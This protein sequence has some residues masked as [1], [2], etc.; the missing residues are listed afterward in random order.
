MADKIGPLGLFSTARGAGATCRCGTPSLSNARHAA[1][2]DPQGIPGPHLLGLWALSRVLV[3]G[4]VGPGAAVH[5]PILRIPFA[6][7]HAPF[8]MLSFK[9]NSHPLGYIL[10]S[11]HHQPSEARAIFSE[12]DG[13]NWPSRAANLSHPCT[14]LSWVPRACSSG[15][16]HSVPVLHSTTPVL[17]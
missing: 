11:L 4:T 3:V 14:N 1:S 2:R 16:V 13:K 6:S 15:H 17:L 5:L 8:Y 10:W 9:P 7:Q 12:W